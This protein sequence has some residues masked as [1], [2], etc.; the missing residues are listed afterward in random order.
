MTYTLPP[1]ECPECGE[2]VGW[3]WDTCRACGYE[4]PVVWEP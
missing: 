3:M 4:F 2:P 1:P